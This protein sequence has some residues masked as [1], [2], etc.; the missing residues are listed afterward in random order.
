MPYS[1][2]CNTPLSNFESGQNYKDVRDPAVI[3]NFPIIGQENTYLLAWTTTPWTLPSNLALCVRS[4]MTY[5]KI[6]DVETGRLY[7]LA[8]SRLVQ[9]YPKLKKKG[10]AGKAGSSKKKNKKKKNKKKKGKAQEEAAPAAADDA[11]EAEKTETLPYELIEKC[12]GKDLAGLEYTPL[13][14][15]FADD[16]EMKDCKMFRVIMD[17]YVDDSSGV[18]IVHQAPAFGEDDYRVC[19]A[20]GVIVRGGKVPCPVDDNGRFT[21]VVADFKGRY[22]KEADRDIIRFLKDAGRMVQVDQI[23]HSYP[24]CWRSDSPLIYKAVPSWFINVPSIKDRLLANN[25]KTYWVPDFVKTKRF[26]NWLADARDWAVSR[27]RYWGTPLPIWTSEDGEEVVVIGSV[28][29]LKELTGEDN[30]TDLHRDSI[31]HLTIPS[32]QGKGVLKRVPEVFDCW[33]ESGSM[34]Y[35]QSHYPFENKES[36]EKGFPADFIAEGLDQT[37]GWFYTLMVLST[38][39]FDKP[40]FKNLIVNGLVLASDGK[41]M[42]KRLK[43]YPDPLEVVREHGADALRLYLIDS[44]VVR[45]EPLKFEKNGVREVVKNIFIP[46]Y[47]TYRLFVEQSRRISKLTGAPFQYD[48]EVHSKTTNSFDKWII[49]S[50]QSLITRTRAEMKAYRLYNVIPNLVSFVVSLSKWYIRFNKERLKGDFGAEEN[51]YALN[52]TFEVLIN[53]CRL[54]GPFTPFLVETMYKNLKQ[55]L[56]AA[57]RVDSVHYL[58]VP[59]ADPAKEDAVIEEQV[60]ALQDVVEMGRVLRDRIPFGFRMPMPECILSHRE[61]KEL[62]KIKPL[63]AYVKT[64]LNIEGEVIFDHDISK[65]VSYT[66][67]PNR[68]SLGLRLRGKASVVAKAIAAFD[69]D[70]IAA[71]ESTGAA[72]VTVGGE[73]F[74]ISLDDVAIKSNFTGDQDTYVAEVQNGFLLLLKQK[75]DE[76]CRQIGLVREFTS[77]IQQHRKTAKLSPEDPIQVFLVPEPSSA[78]AVDMCQNRVGLLSK[79]LRCD[80]HT[81]ESKPLPSDYKESLE[82]KIDETVEFEGEKMQVVIASA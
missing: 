66:A 70:Q 53:L 16:A 32:K 81:P 64:Q 57:D 34:P 45:A 22:V 68:K 50:L 47:N 37:R 58:M 23:L 2:T 31:D 38:A 79:A 7:W 54:M 52:I 49:A 74:P 36:F 13:F 61:S 80:V 71:L 43:N 56:P 1:T 30:I 19:I 28:A 11:K 3:V 60:S 62:N 12:E 75:P 77:R 21:D 40:A 26:H 10:D 78:G 69:A 67:E 65:Y 15:Y 20:N 8:E 17:D 63:E 72:V 59:E 39:L 27:N 6:K 48:P 41:K 5:I 35:A 33:F 55:G 76:K 9:L 44:P 4:D 51:I 25:D 18:G 29:E 14:P 46:W 73:E 42:S 24:H 82:V